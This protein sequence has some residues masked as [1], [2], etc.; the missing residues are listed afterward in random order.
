MK[1]AAVLLALCGAFHFAITRAQE[2]FKIPNPDVPY[3]DSS[4]T[5]VQGDVAELAW[6]A[7]CMYRRRKTE[8]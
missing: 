4:L 6:S 5:I 1:S 8:G 2:G 7:N 3:L